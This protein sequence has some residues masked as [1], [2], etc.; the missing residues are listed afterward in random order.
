[1]RSRTPSSLRSPPLLRAHRTGAGSD[2]VGSPQSV[3][4]G[5][6]I[7]AVAARLPISGAASNDGSKIEFQQ[8][9]FAR[10][11][12]YNARW[13]A[14]GKT[15][16][17]SVITGA[18]YRACASCAPNIRRRSRSVL[19]SL[20]SWLCRRRMKSRCS[21]TRTTSPIVS[22]SARSRSCRL[23]VVL[24]ARSSRMCTRR[25]GLGW[26]AVGHHAP[27]RR[28]MTRSS[29]QSG[30][31]ST[32][33]RPAVTSVIRAYPPTVSASRLSSTRIA[34][35]IAASCRGRH[36]ACCVAPGRGVRRHRR[37]G[38]GVDDRTMLFSAAHAAGGLELDA[39][40][41]WRQR[42]V[43]SAP[44][45]RSAHDVRRARRALVGLT[46]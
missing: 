45:R 40:A 20:N 29:T 42:F 18:V 41:G 44:Q 43:Q 11:A 22:S 10:E 30:R 1:M 27:R 2:A 6:L 7:G 35:T 16:L 33:G 14:D 8:R 12:I 19:R 28:T 3:V 4:A 26:Y 17:Y 34:V 9:T 46:R 39:L 32:A 5:V 23:A 24:R 13:G 25:I 38:L 31:Y 36:E 21:S 37:D 15:I